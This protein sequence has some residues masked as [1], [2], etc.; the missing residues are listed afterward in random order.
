M[1]VS[2][3]VQRITGLLWRDKMF[4][5]RKQS[6][7]HILSPATLR[8]P[9]SFLLCL[10]VVST[11][12]ATSCAR[13]FPVQHGTMNL[14]ETNRGSFPLG[15]VLQYSCDPGYSVDGSSIIICTREGVWSPE[16]PRCVPNNLCRPPF[17]P[18]NGGY[19][20]HPS[21][22]GR[23]TQ[24]TVIEYFC[25]EGYNLKGDYRYLTCQN[26]EW[27]GPMQISCL[28]IQ[29][30]ARPFPIQHGTM[31]LSE[32]NR[33][34]YPLGTVLQYSCDPGYT[35]DGSSSITCT[36]ESAWSPG[37]P[38]CVRT[39]LCRPPFEPENGGYTCHPS[40]CG[41]LTQGTVIEYFCDEGYNL[42]G[43]YRY[44]TCQNGE[45]DGPMQISCLPTQ[46]KDAAPVLGMNTLS[47][48][49]STASSVALVLLLIVLFVLL[50]PKL[51]SF[52]H[53]RREHGSP[54]QAVTIMVEGVQVTLPTYEEAVSGSAAVSSVSSGSQTPVALAEEPRTTQAELH[55]VCSSPSQH[56][57]VAAV[58]QAPS[59]SSSSSS[60]SWSLVPGALAASQPQRRG[61]GGSEQHGLPLQ[62][63]AVDVSDDIP[64]LKEA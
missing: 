16:P 61:S 43:D 52:H 56:S 1:V 34:S 18:E 9:L 14:S 6:L 46:E 55:H 47:I 19:T 8:L 3:G 57:D 4:D 48:V 59:S 64:L 37:P 63:S 60:L 40:P 10:S 26:G 58:H 31:N 54:G 32:T 33:G 2:C 53:G 42:K 27:D 29:G 41:R 36:R 20:C 23:L 13:P 12:Q 49:A 35:L 51:K 11:V 24:G 21:P 22:C 17:E 50:Q 38:R 28:P 30:C 7:A 15:T 45:W 62:A 44:L 39:N 25:D 5:G